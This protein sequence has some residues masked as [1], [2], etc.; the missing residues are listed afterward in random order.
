M[1][2]MTPTDELAHL[3]SEKTRLLNLNPDNEAVQMEVE[4]TLR[5]MGK[6]RQDHPE[7]AGIVMNWEVEL[8]DACPKADPDRE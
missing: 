3:R 8:L 7:H 4:S 1:G 2:T 6:F 5:A